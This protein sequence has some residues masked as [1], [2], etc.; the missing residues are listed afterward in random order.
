MGIVNVTPD[1][2]SG[3]G[4]LNLDAAVAHA[5][6]LAEHGADILDVGGESSRPGAE[7]VDPEEEMHRVVPVIGQLSQ[8]T[9]LPI[10]VDTRHAWVA[11]A[12]LVAGATLV[13]DVWGFLQDPELG[14]VVSRHGAW[15]VAMHNRKGIAASAPKVGGYVSEAPAGDVVTDVI[16]GLRTS[17]SVLRAAGVPDDRIIVDPGFGFGKTPPQNLQLIAQLGRLKELGFPILV[18]PSRKSTIGIVLG[19]LPPSERLEG[20]AAL[21]ALS[22]ANGADIVRVHDLPAMARVVRMTDAV[23][24]GRAEG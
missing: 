5:L 2:F 17:V 10:S 1:S 16:Q 24:R 8:R 23:V 11:Q 22:I 6:D 14:H 12:A 21:V 13:N 20:T 18:G 15:A 19:G 9:E 3:D 7:P 4:S